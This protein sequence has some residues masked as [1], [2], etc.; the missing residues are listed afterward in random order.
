MVTL[1]IENHE[2][3]I[4]GSQTQKVLKRYKEGLLFSCEEGYILSTSTTVRLLRWLARRHLQLSMAQHR[5]LPFLA[6][7]GCSPVYESKLTVEGEN[8]ERRNI[9]T[10]VPCR[11]DKYPDGD[12]IRSTVQG[13]MEGRYSSKKT[14]SPLAKIKKAFAKLTTRGLA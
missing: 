3:V 1:S 12:W 14:N 8:H 9:L 6:K 11:A 10:W 7:P 2:I 13:A 4:R 5:D